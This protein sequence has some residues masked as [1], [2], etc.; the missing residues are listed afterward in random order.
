[1]RGGS[2]DRLG[3]GGVQGGA[4]QVWGEVFEGGGVCGARELVR[5]GG[6]RGTLCRGLGGSERPRR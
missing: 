1:M 6:A 4:P 2:G 5:N 3:K